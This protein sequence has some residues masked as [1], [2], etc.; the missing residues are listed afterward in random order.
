[1]NI[2][3][4]GGAGFIGSNLTS[5][6]LENY[7]GAIIIDKVRTPQ[8]ILETM[9]NVTYHCGNI[10]DPHLMN[11][12]FSE[13]D[14]DGIIHLAAVS[15]VVW[16]ERDPG[17]CYDVNVNGTINLVN[18]IRNHCDHPWVIFGSSREVYGEPSKLP[19]TEDCPKVPINIYG[20]TKLKGE[21]LVSELAREQG[22]CVGILRFSNVYGNE[23]D[24][25]DRVIPRFI[26]RSLEN[27]PVEIHGGNQSFDFTH[28]DD[29]I[30]GIERTIDHLERKRS[31]GDVICDDFHILPG[32]PSSLQRIVDL[33]SE[34]LDRDIEQVYTSPRNYDVERF[35]GNPKK[36][37]KVLGFKAQIDIKTGISR[38]IR[39]YEEV[40]FS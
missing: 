29:T 13:N 1:M 20:R 7:D 18:A 33:I 26:L 15:R 2:L 19:V 39:R 35:C 14:I 36:A 16:G 40:F 28:I 31:E 25:L 9:E 24:I 4:T 5:R 3:I 8:N 32:E 34:C 11:R 10:I 38:T 23:K 27:N 30:D 37:Y 21:G 6:I 17:L 12:I 22:L